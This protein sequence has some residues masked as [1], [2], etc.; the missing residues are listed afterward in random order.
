MQLGMINYSHDPARVLGRRGF[1]RPALFAM[2]GLNFPRLGSR[3]VCGRVTE[4]ICCK[5]LTAN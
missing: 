4:G 1:I 2:A 5:Q 3:R